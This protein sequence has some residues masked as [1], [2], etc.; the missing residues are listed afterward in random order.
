MKIPLIA[1]TIVLFQSSFGIGQSLD[2]ETLKHCQ[3]ATV[4]IK[5]AYFDE[6]RKLPNKQQNNPVELIGTGFVIG[7]NTNY[8]T[9]LTTTQVLGN[10]PKGTNRMVDVV[11][12]SGIIQK[13]RR[14]PAAVVATD[15]KLGLAMIHVIKQIGLEIKPILFDPQLK[16]AL[17]STVFALGY[18]AGEING[19]EQAPPAFAATK[20]SV[21]SI[22]NSLLAEPAIIQVDTLNNPGNA[23]GPV[24]NQN[25]HL[26]G[27]STAQPKGPKSLSCIANQQTIKM[28][29]ARMLGWNS[30]C[31]LLKDR[32]I[33]R[34]DYELLDY[35]EII[36]SC[37]FALK[38][39]DQPLPPAGNEPGKLDGKFVEMKLVGS[40]AFGELD[41]DMGKDHPGF[42]VQPII[43]LIGGTKI[44]LKPEKAEISNSLKYHS[45]NTPPLKECIL[46][47]NRIKKL[48][49][50]ELASSTPKPYEPNPP[51]PMVNPSL[52]SD[53]GFSNIL[54]P[55]TAYQLKPNYTEIAEGT[56]MNAKEMWWGRG[57][58]RTG[59]RPIERVKYHPSRMV[60]SRDGKSFFAFHRNHGKI[61]KCSFPEMEIQQQLDVQREITWLTL[62]RDGLLATIPELQ[63]SW[64]IN[65]DNM[66][67]IKKVET[68]ECVRF[69]A[70]TTSSYAIGHQTT[71]F[72]SK[73]E[74]KLV[75]LDTSSGK[76]IQDM[77]VSSPFNDPIMFRTL[78]S[79][80][81]ENYYLIERDRIVTMT[82]G[83]NGELKV[84]K[85]TLTTENTVLFM[86][87]SFISP[88]GKYLGVVTK[89]REN[90]SRFAFRV[91][92][93]NT[94]E[95][96]ADNIP[97]KLQAT[98]SSCAFNSSRK[99]IIY[100]EGPL[101]TIHVCDFEGK[102]IRSHNLTN[103][104]PN[105][106]HQILQHSDSD[107]LLV[108]QETIR[109][110]GQSI[111]GVILK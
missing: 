42:Y 74:Y 17:T 72:Q 77:Q 21:S 3:S 30:Y 92:D 22:K 31:Q 6:S 76:I 10:T 34:V 71:S 55:A 73:T 19:K 24:V 87:Y 56:A 81:G 51:I 50:S 20:G 65:E 35:L 94:M 53:S 4:L 111:F 47:A 79:P 63:E 49:T 15:P 89:L 16:P 2:K 68:K 29:A 11:F 28:F 64:L 104:R 44:Y 8:W 88:D 103:M 70:S 43:E 36:K 101:T 106:V 61:V 7:G 84:K 41:F 110:P 1:C 25:G 97:S 83:R 58:L 60:W 93:S 37:S 48:I 95:I 13:E 5:V 98:T 27:I 85:E 90:P 78:M 105:Y 86:E 62:C 14:L 96:V 57:I 45:I 39:A 69:D 66:K 40:R 33:L 38:K 23:G 102:E 75:V 100:N 12:S 52:P 9:I 26:I 32:S 107:H 99:W 91:Y 54:E 46:E 108:L 59:I 109:T 82:V 18:P 67:V 80:N